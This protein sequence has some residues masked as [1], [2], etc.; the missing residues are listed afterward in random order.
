MGKEQTVN[1]AIHLPLHFGNVSVQ[2]K[3]NVSFLPD[4]FNSMQYWEKQKKT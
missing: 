4:N 2:F 3:N 1:E